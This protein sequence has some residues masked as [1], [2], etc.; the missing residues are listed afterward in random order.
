MGSQT[1]ESRR[2]LQAN[3]RLHLSAGLEEDVVLEQDGVTFDADI[4]GDLSLEAFNSFTFRL[5]QYLQV[6][7]RLGGSW[8]HSMP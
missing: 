8:S 4:V 3:P 7:T 1:F 2:V 5:T 6:G